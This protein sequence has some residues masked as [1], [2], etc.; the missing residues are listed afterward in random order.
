[1]RAVDTHDEVLARLRED[2]LTH[3]GRVSLRALGAYEIGYSCG[4]SSL[5]LQGLPGS[6][7]PE[8]HQ[9]WIHAKICKD[10]TGEHRGRLNAGN[11]MSLT[12]AARLFSVDDRAAFETYLGLR[13]EMIRECGAGVGFT[14]DAR[15]SFGVTLQRVLARPAMFFGND[16]TAGELWAFCSGFRWAEVDVNSESGEVASVFAGFQTWMESRYPFASGRSWDRILDWLMLGSA[17][18]ALE[19]FAS[20]WEMF[21]GGH[22]FDAPDPVQAQM[23]R[24][25]VDHAR[26][27]EDAK[28]PVMSRLRR[29]LARLTS[30]R[31]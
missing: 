30:R 2:P 15:E 27:L 17:A 23:M 25:I 24:S 1:M 16:Y 11:A 26:K 3:L 5:G 18:G 31:S 13:Q 29:M 28:M 19:S 22:P 10:M 8:Q 6:S 9:A 12:S 4:R 20:H 21:Q 7:Y 14:S